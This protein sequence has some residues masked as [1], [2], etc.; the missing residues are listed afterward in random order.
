MWLHSLGINTEGTTRT[1]VLRLFAHSVPMSRVSF[2]GS[3]ASQFG[4]S[5]SMGRVVTGRSSGNSSGVMHSRRPTRRHSR[6]PREHKVPRPPPFVDNRLSF[7]FPAPAVKASTKS[8]VG[9]VRGAPEPIDD[10]LPDA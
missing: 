8:T 6:A 3:P 10:H 7:V 5:V 2:V 9:G 4:G 1:T